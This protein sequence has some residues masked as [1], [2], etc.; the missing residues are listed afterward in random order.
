[1]DAGQLVPDDIVVSLIMQELKKHAN[2][3]WLLDGKFLVWQ[4]ISPL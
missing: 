2:E 1:M 4:G 3:H